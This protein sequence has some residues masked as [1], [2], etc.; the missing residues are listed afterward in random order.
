MQTNQDVIELEVKI[1]VDDSSK[2]HE[3]KKYYYNELIEL[4]NTLTLI[5]GKSEEHQKIFQYFNDV[6][7]NKNERKS[8]SIFI[9]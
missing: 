8:I 9:L 2:Q 6:S 1:P 3:I 7:M 5:V 4:N